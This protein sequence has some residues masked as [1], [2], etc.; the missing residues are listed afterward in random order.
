PL[1]MPTH[2]GVRVDEDERGSPA[3]PR[4]GQ[5][6][7]EQSVPAR[8]SHSS[9]GAFQCDQLLSQR[10]VFTNQFAVSAAGQ[11]EAADDDKEHLK[12]A[13]NSAG[14]SRRGSIY[15]RCAIPIVPN[16]RCDSP[17]LL[18]SSSRRSPSAWTAWCSSAS[19]ISRLPSESSSTTIRKNGPTRVWTTNSSLRKRR[20]RLRSAPDK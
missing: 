1:T 6:D 9:A 10:Q 14:S 8:D 13:V 2:D 17:A 7:P 19:G 5:R 11:R 15:S 3:P 12:H 4:C 20:R 16:D 18:D